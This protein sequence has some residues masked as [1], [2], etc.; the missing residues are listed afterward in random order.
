MTNIE[1]ADSR[2][3]EGSQR[4]WRLIW[5]AFR[6]HHLGMVGL[7]MLSL[8]VLGVIL[9]PVLLPDPYGRVATDASL[10]AAPIG[11]VDPANG[12]RFLLGSDQYGRDNLALVFEAGR[13]SLIVAVIPTAMILLI[14]FV[15]GALAGYYGGWIDNVLMRVV[16]FLLALPLLPAYLIGLRVLNEQEARF[17]VLP[18]QEDARDVLMAL[19]AVFVFFGWTGVSRLVRG[20]VL[21]LRT[22]A[23]IE[24]ARALGA[25]TRTIM[26]R[27]LMPNIATPLLVVGMFAIG[28]FIVMEAMLSYF[29]MG[30]R[31]PIHPPVV[32]WGNIVATNIDQTWYITNPNP[33]QQIRG[34]LSI[35]PGVLL[36]ITVLSIN[37]VGDALRDVLDPHR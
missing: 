4:Q 15:V 27:H 24:A 34:Y 20:R 9:V 25:S 32:S 23:Y 37:F 22:Q 13:L 14:G 18:L 1:F 29:G 11:A 2:F 10:W 36:F 3:D 19:I 33:F 35:F 30:F 12:H 6:K 7:A 28:D 21:S 17:R 8:V 26:F 16:D 5:R 31:D